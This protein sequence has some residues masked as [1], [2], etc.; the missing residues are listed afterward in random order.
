MS[1]LLCLFME[2]VL[3]IG[4]LYFFY[5]YNAEGEMPDEK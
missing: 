2:G 3:L 4:A 5:D 1:L